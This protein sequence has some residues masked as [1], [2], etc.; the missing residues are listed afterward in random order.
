MMPVPSGLEAPA[1]RSARV[2]WEELSARP[3]PSS[4]LDPEVALQKRREHQKVIRRWTGSRPSGSILKTDLFEDAFGLDAIFSDLFEDGGVR[5]FGMDLAQGTVRAACDRA[6]AGTF[7]GLVCD[8][9]RLPVRCE[10]LDLVISTSTLD[11]FN[12][13]AEFLSALG[14]LCAALKPGGALVITLDNPWNPLYPLLR[15]AARLGLTPFQL[16]Y[17][18]APGHLARLL[19]RH[20]VEVLD[21]GWLIHNPRLLSTV[22]FRGARRL[23]GSRADAVIRWLLHVFALQERLPTRRFT[24]CFYA[25]YARKRSSRG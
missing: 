10:C 24:A 3:N 16:G 19:R 22:L 1:L 20:G 4:Y 5:L 8:V 2:P 6:G 7:L 12:T 13:R 23:A 25:L 17:T 14:Q 18:P 11:H 21:R 15:L 9:R